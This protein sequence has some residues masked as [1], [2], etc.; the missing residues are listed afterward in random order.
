LRSLKWS[1]TSNAVDHSLSAE[2]VSTL[3]RR[4]TGQMTLLCPHVPAAELA[5]LSSRLAYTELANAAGMTF[6]HADTD[7]AVANEGNHIVWLPGSSTAIVLPAGEEEGRLAVAKARAAAWIRRHGALLGRITTRGSA[8]ARQVGV[9]L[10]N[11][12]QARLRVQ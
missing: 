11:A 4:I 7:D 6:E 1:F 5:D 3:A 8:V 9:A 2:N 10:V 12:Y